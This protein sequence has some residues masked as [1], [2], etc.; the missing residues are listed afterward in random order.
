MSQDGAELYEVIEKV[1][2]DTSGLFSQGDVTDRPCPAILVGPNAMNSRHYQVHYRVTNTMPEQKPK[3]AA[4]NKPPYRI[5]TMEEIRAMTPNGF[6]A[7]STFSGC[8]GSST[9]YRMAGFPILYAN[10]FVPAARDSYAANKAEYT[11]LD[12]RD[13]REVTPDDV[14][15]KMNLRQGELDLFDGSPPCASFSTAGKREAGWGKVKKYSDVEQRTDDLFFEYA[16]LLRGLQPRTFVAENVSGLVKGTAK[17]YFK[18]ILAEL[19]ACGYRVG[20]Q[21]LDAQWLGV[22]QSRQRLIFMGV[23]EDLEMDPVFPRPL[24]YRYT[25]RDAIPW[26]VRHGTAPPHA[27]FVASNR[28]IDATMVDSASHPCPTITTGYATGAEWDKFRPGEKSSKYFQLVKPSLDEACPTI[29]AAGGNPGLAS[30]CHPLEK[31][32]FSIEELK[33]ICGFPDDFDLVG[34]YQQRWER[35]GRAVPPEM[36][37]HIAM[38][39]RDNILTPLRDRGRI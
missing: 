26:I 15:A 31:R 16:R 35:C 1:V 11:Y 7:A 14:L 33:R 25:V 34:S 17:G 6:T 8:G 2:H 20:A 32:K 37:R 21:V 13:I 9:G 29:T 23:R 22:P 10:E 4:A 5:M 28:S 39:V 19:R 24:P 12:G 27:D 30:V 3:A 36:M 38:S 18:L